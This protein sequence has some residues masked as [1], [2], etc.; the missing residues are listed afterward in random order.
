MRIS[1]DAYCAM[2]KSIPGLYHLSRLHR[3]ITETHYRQRKITILKLKSQFTSKENFDL[4]YE[5][6]SK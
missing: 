3:K 4:R 6:S 1:E 5:H 2:N